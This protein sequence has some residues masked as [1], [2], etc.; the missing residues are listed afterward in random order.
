MKLRLYFAFSLLLVSIFSISKSFA[1]DLPS[2]PFP[3]PGSDE[4]LFVVRNTTIKTESPVKAIVEDYWTNRTIKRKPNK[5]VYGQSVFTTA[6]S[7]W[8]SAYMTVN[9]N[10]HNYTMA[11]LSGYKHGTSTVFT[12]SE[13]TSLNQDFYSV[14]S[15]VDDSEESIPSINYLDETPEY[16]VTVEA[17][18]SGNGHMF[19]MCISNKLSFGECKSQI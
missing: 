6:G 7:K 19:V 16:F 9:I 11:A 17:Y 18:E 2:I 1:I 10:G 4:L 8:L 13:K 5:D 15:F 3:S 12:K 14:K